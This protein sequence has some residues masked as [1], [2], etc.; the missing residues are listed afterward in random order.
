MLEHNK[1][2]SPKESLRFFVVYRQDWFSLLFGQYVK[3]CFGQI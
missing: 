2:K 3:Y 1:K